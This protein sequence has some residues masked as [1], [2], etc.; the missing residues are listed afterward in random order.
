MLSFPSSPSIPAALLFGAGGAC[1]RFV[2]CGAGTCAVFPASASRT[3]SWMKSLFSSICDFD[4]PMPCNCVNKRSHDGSTFSE[5]KPFSASKPM[6]AMCL[7]DVGADMRDL[8]KNPF[9]FFFSFG[10]L[11]LLDGERCRDGIPSVEL[12]KDPLGLLLLAV[13]HVRYSGQLSARIARQVTYCAPAY[14]LRFKTF[15]FKA[16]ASLS[17]ENAMPI[18][19]S[20]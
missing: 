13:I 10:S 7:K 8:L 19:H 2:F 17:S 5:V 15:L 18:I 1:F 6:C 11:S 3:K 20:C 12:R 9:F 14:F 4:I 16:E